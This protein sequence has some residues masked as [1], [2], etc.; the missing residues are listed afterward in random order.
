MTLPHPT[1]EQAELRSLGLHTGHA[2]LSLAPAPLHPPHRH[3]ASRTDPQPSTQAAT[4]DPPRPPTQGRTRPAALTCPAARR[5]VRRGGP[6]RYLHRARRPPLPIRTV[7]GTVPPE[8]RRRRRRRQQVGC[9]KVTA[10][11]RSPLWGAPIRPQ[12][13]SSS[14]EQA[15]PVRL[16]GSRLGEREEERMN[17]Y[18]K[19]RSLSHFDPP[20]RVGK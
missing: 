17:R 16:C 6:C 10:E 12:P 14:E 8:S 5:T 11:P 4:T 15:L 20:P 7:R 19:F 3:V 18:P 13:F 1:D 9:W 2:C